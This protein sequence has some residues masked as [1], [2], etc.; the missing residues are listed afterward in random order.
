MNL[1]GTT[2][3]VALQVQ[4]LFFILNRTLS[5]SFCTSLFSNPN[6][7]HLDTI[8][9][10]IL[11]IEG[12]NYTSQ[13]QWPVSRLIGSFVQ[14]VDDT[15]FP[16]LLPDNTPNKTWHP[17]AYLIPDGYN[18]QDQ[19][20]N[21]YYD[22][23]EP[24]N[25]TLIQ[26]SH[27]TTSTG[28]GNGTGN[29]NNASENNSTSRLAGWLIAVIVIASVVFVLSI[30]AL[31]WFVRRLKR[32]KAS[33]ENEGDHRN[34]FQAP[35]GGEMSAPTITAA[36]PFAAG[37]IHNSNDISSIHSSTP[38]IQRNGPSSP[39]PPPASPTPLSQP[40][41]A[42]HVMQHHDARQSSSILS[43]TD[44]IMIADT[45]R[46]FMR[47]PEWNEHHDEEEEEEAFKQWNEPPKRKPLGD[48]LFRKADDGND[49]NEQQ[50]PS[51]HQQ[52][53]KTPQ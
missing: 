1:H 27:N 17:S 46:Q 51:S 18:I 4:F 33:M 2:S 3:M 30:L 14:Q 36:R 11:Y 41:V 21:N 52:R 24:V 48:D 38:M 22:F 28:S 45:F 47:K 16:S 50:D 8:N 53:S 32:N 10:H 9:L 42:Q 12:H 7:R 20:D 26:S 34:L 44:A 6:F 40:S 5:S 43:S 25:F 29:T 35:A 15:W 13:K 37:S 49:S 23:P 19:I 31:I 39:T